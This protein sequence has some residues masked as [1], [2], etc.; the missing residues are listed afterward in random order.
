MMLA[1]VNQW[2]ARLDCA[3]DHGHQFETL[4]AKRNLV[5]CDSRD[6]K[7]VINQPGYV[8]YLALDHVSEL[9]ELWLRRANPLD[10]SNGVRDR[11]ERIPELVREHRQ[12]L[13]LAPIVLAQLLLGLS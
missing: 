8:R 4:L 6:V 11:R 5:P 3:S 7:Q 10:R 2:A 13:I 1:R 12:K 9:Q